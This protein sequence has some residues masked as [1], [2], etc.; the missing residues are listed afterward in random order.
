MFSCEVSSIV[1]YT[2]ACDVQHECLFRSI[3]QALSHITVKC[4]WESK[5][6]DVSKTRWKEAT[7]IKKYSN[8]LENI[9]KVCWPFFKIRRTSSAHLRRHESYFV[10]SSK[11]NWKQSHLPLS[12][13]V[14][15]WCFV[16]WP[17]GDDNTTSA[18]IVLK[19]HWKRPKLNF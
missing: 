15:G 5:P 19:L 11:K 10:G 17:T 1:R 12:F 4:L 3:F 8:A 9:L 14:L 6:G 13:S 18:V 16:L 2:N 7:L